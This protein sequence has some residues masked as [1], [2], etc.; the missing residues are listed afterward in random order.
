MASESGQAKSSDEQ[1][2]S[3]CGETI[4]K[5]AE[6]CPECGVSQDGG[7]EN[8]QKDPG[9]AALISLFIPGIGHYWA[10]NESHGIYWFLG[11]SIWYVVMFVGFFLVF[12]WAMAFATPLVHIGAA[13]HA[14]VSLT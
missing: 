5:D 10:G 4:K 6:I 8:Q 1:F 3:S 11:T 12:G 7:S 14:Y 9:I 2:C 13:I